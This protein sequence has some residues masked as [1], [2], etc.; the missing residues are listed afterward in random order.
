MASV[1]TSWDARLRQT[2]HHLKTNRA[3]LNA[4]E[5]VAAIMLAGEAAAILWW[6]ASL[7]G[8]VKVLLAA[9]MAVTIGCL[10]WAGL[11]PLF[12][13]VFIYDIVRTSRRNRYFYV[14]HT[15]CIHLEHHAPSGAT[16]SF[17]ATRTGPTGSCATTTW[18]AFRAA[19]SMC[20]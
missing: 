7:S 13:P 15:L 12:G 10:R 16:G 11:F 19:F 17:T 3:V 18:S 4:A 6:H 2:F 14:A 9:Q 8:P 5:I 20:S 1:D